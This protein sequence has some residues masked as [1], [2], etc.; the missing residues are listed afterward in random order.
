MHQYGTRALLD[1]RRT[2]IAAALGALLFTLVGGAGAHAKDGRDNYVIVVV[3]AIPGERA[4]AEDMVRSSGGKVG[5]P[6][7]VI[8]GSPRAFG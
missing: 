7:N 2:V 4:A 6:L 8:T 5:R 1:I 3:Q